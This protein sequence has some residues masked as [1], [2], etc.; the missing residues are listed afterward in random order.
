MKK[1]NDKSNVNIVSNN[2][3]LIKINTVLGRLSSED[4]SFITD[5][6]A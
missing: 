4:T 2:D 3:Q 5:E 6:A 1:N